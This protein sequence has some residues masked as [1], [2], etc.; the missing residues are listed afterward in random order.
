MQIHEITKLQ[1]Q[2]DEGLLSGLKSAVSTAKTGVGK[3]AKAAGPIA[4]KIA[5]KTADAL[6]LSTVAPGLMGGFGVRDAMAAHKAGNLWSPGGIATARKARL[7]KDA[8]A[9]LAILA[10]RGITPTSYKEKKDAEK[11]TQQ[12]QN[13]PNLVGIRSKLDRRFPQE[14]EVGPPPGG[15]AEKPEPTASPGKEL[16]VE[17]PR[18]P[19][20]TVSSY[21]IK[22]ATG[23]KTEEGKPITNPDS[24]AFLNKSIDK[25][26]KVAPNLSEAPEDVGG[27]SAGGIALPPGAKTAGPKKLPLQFDTVN[28][29]IARAIPDYSLIKNDA[30]TQAALKNQFTKIAA[31]KNNAAAATKLF[32]QYVLI[33]QTAISKAKLA[34]NDTETNATMPTTATSS[35]N[36]DMSQWR[37]RSLS[38]LQRDPKFIKFM[39]DRGIGLNEDATKFDRL[40]EKLNQ[41]LAEKY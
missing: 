2:L 18:G 4:K 30:K 22:T 28:G 32:D 3:I 29:W 23:W 34:S 33:M 41:L 27:F 7:Q 5:S 1:N 16:K 9:N 38:D 14:F 37:G 12:V 6:E 35:S 8:D 13:D 10:K 25:E 31:A 24:I 40:D 39:G 11:A 21:A 15:T 19:G 26:Y 17:L 36:A 20:Q